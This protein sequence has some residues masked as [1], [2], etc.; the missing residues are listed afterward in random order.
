MLDFVYSYF[1]E[2]LIDY[3]YLIVTIEIVLTIIML[4]FL[5]NFCYWLIKLLGGDR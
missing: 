1:G 3:P 2:W 4:I 5:Y